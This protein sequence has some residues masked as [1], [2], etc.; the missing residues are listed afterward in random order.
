MLRIF[1]ELAAV[2]GVERTCDVDI[3]LDDADHHVRL[4]A[5]FCSLAR[6]G[7]VFPLAGEESEAL[8]SQEMR[9]PD[10]HR[11]GNPKDKGKDT[12]S[13]NARRYNVGGVLLSQPFKI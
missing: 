8:Q 10:R 9:R 3:R 1:R 13:A 4:T 7:Q 12:M 2:R 6:V 11:F 5:R